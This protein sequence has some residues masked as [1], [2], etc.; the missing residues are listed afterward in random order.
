MNE[1]DV[2]MS[3]PMPLAG[4]VGGANTPTIPG[5]PVNQS[6]VDSRDANDFS[7]QVNSSEKSKAE[8]AELKEQVIETFQRNAFQ[9]FSEQQKK[10]IEEIKKDFN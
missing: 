10:A 1:K 5:T 7:S 6:A 3:G 4:Q 8:E 2:M 9:S